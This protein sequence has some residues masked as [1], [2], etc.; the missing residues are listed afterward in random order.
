M[1][2]AMYGWIEFDEKIKFLQVLVYFCALK[3]ELYMNQV[4]D[5]VVWAMYRK[6]E[7]D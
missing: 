6:I 3:I 5:A 1:V 4:S 2:L 7:F